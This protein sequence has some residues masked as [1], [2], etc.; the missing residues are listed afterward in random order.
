[1]GPVGSRNCS[2]VLAKTHTSCFLV[3]LFPHVFPLNATIGTKQPRCQALIYR[4]NSVISQIY[5]PL[6]TGESRQRPRDIGPARIR[7]LL[8]QGG[9][10]S[11]DAA[12]PSGNVQNRREKGQPSR[13]I[14]GTRAGGGSQVGGR[15]QDLQASTPGKDQVL[16]AK[17]L[18]ESACKPGSVEDNHSSG[19]RV[20]ARLKRPTRIRRG[21]RR[22]IPIWSCSEWG[23][24]CRS[25]YHERGALLPHHFTLTCHQPRL[26]SGRYIFCGTFRRLTPPR[27]YLAP[28]PM[29]PGLSSALHRKPP[30]GRATDARTAVVQPTPGYNL[31]LRR[32]ICNQHFQADRSP[33]LPARASN[34]R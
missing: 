26:R 16:C 8:H 32:F 13:I 15:P 7:P 24:P 10:H 5:R 4:R 1:M 23:L 20:T 12:Y 18:K 19:A 11:R 30:N 9:R 25:Y 28:C 29:E 21:Q 27:G 33:S 2:V 3:E 14:A 34:L 22:W 17:D 31:V 6:P